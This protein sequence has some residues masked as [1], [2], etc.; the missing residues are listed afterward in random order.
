M[1]IN[2]IINGPI[3]KMQGCG[4]DFVV[5]KDL[6]EQL[7]PQMAEKIC[8][9]HFGIGSDG[10]IAVLKSRVPEAEYRMKFFNPDGSLAE[11]CGNGIRCFAKY[12]RDNVD[13][14]M[15]IR[16]V[17]TDAGIVKPEVL[18]N[19]DVEA[20]VKVNMGEPVLYNPKQVI[21]KPNKRGIVYSKI[22]DH[23]FTFVSM[24]NPHAVMFTQFPEVN[25]KKYGPVVEH[26][27]EVFPQKTNV[28][29]VKVNS[30]TDLT[31]YVWER[32]AGETLACGTGACASLVASVLNGHS[33]DH[34]RLHLLGG[35]LEISWKGKGNPVYMTGLARNVCR[36]DA[37]SLDKY[38]LRK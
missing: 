20:L 12:L 3:M 22:G 24:G 10:L 34:A 8:D 6:E 38:L 2:E 21:G 1:K 30:S 32:G 35:D 13:G 36:I 11:M 17:D 7:T 14:I 37:E 27:T 4:N 15:G 9:R 25:V 5:I 18:E 19:G 29:F 31:M 33:E 16:L 28:E 23:E 26:S